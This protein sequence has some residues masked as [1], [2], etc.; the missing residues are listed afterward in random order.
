M[1]LIELENQLRQRYEVIKYLSMADFFNLPSSTLYRELADA[2]QLEF[3]PQQRIVFTCF[4]QLSDDQVKIFLTKLQKCL[5]FL[6][7]SNFFVLIASNRQWIS[8]FATEV[9]ILHAMSSE[10]NSFSHEYYN[11]ESGS[12]KIKNVSIL[13]PPDTMCAYPWISLDITGTGEF[14]P[15]CFFSQS[16]TDNRGNE[17]NAAHHTLKEVYNS[18]YMK[19]LRQ[20]FRNGEKP[21][22]CRRCWNEERD[23]VQSKR[24]LLKHR[25]PLHSYDVNWEQDNIENLKLLSIAFGNICNLKCRICQSSNS[26]QIAIEDLSS[27]S[28]LEQKSHKSYQNLV[29]GRW[30]KN[31]NNTLWDQL[32][33]PDLDLAYFDFA[34]G[35]PLLS[36]QHFQVL[37]HFIH[38]GTANKIELHYN[39]NGTVFPTE[40]VDLWNNFKKVDIAVSIDNIDKR[41]ELERNGCNWNEITA[42]LQKFFKIKTES[43]KI[44]LHLAI[45]IQNVLYLP[46]ICHWIE[47]Q[48]FDSI[49]FSNLYYPSALNIQNLTPVAKNVVFNKL[50]N[51]QTNDTVLAKFIS[52][53]VKIVKGAKTSN[54]QDFCQFIKNLDQKRSEN[55]GITH[56]EIAQAMGYI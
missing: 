50:S 16:I 2:H 49:H 47:S 11:I 7:I 45:S 28:K 3:S 29:K 41:A 36:L 38:L 24:L 23:Q 51:Y 27:V 4:D 8:D 31:E 20:Q 56:S 55:F 10:S 15:C 42:N 18:Q 46:E 34:G 25:F 44:S 30:I 6:D 26:S 5:T 9:K 13:N 12:T 14:K 37:K 17:F 19:D 32:I 39:T 54:G 35:E 33:D 43:I 21:G 48:Q 52:E 22:G 40:Y 1:N 53:T